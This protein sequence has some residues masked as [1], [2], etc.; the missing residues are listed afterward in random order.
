MASKRLKT[1]TMT[2]NRCRTCDV[3]LKMLGNNYCPLVPPKGG[4]MQ[5]ITD[6]ELD[7]IPDWCPLPDAEDDA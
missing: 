1:L 6:A 4:R 7:T 2:V 5:E 3:R